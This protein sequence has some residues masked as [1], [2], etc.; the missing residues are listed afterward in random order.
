M[1]DGLRETLC[2][3]GTRAHGSA[4]NNTIHSDKGFCIR[5][6]ERVGPNLPT[7]SDLPLPRLSDPLLMEIRC[8]NP[9]RNSGSKSNEI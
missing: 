7:F 4:Q 9:P 3:R 5:I 2:V 1:M 6:E 8:Y